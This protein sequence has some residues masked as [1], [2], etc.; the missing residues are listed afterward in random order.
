MK[1]ERAEWF[2]WLTARVL[3]QHRFAYH[4]L[5]GSAD[6]VEAALFA[7][8]GPEAGFGYALEPD[9]RGPAPE[10]LSAAFALRLLDEIGRCDHRRT[11]RLLSHF[12]DV[13]TA[14]GGLPARNPAPGHHPASSAVPPVA[15]PPGA[16]QSTGPIIGLLQHNQVRHPWLTRATDFCWAAVE[17]LENSHPYELAAAV[18][19]L[20]GI[21]DQDRA[22]PVARRLGELVRDE[23]LAVLEPEKAQ[24][25]PLMPGYPPMLYHY[26]HDYARTPDSLAR[27]WFT[28]EEMARALDFLESEQDHDGGWA[29]RFPEW[30]PSTSLE[31]RPI[32]TV[33]ALLTLRAYG[34]L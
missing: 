23:R 24:E 8:A 7:Y 26:P 14:D 13:S 9:L 17:S 2:V 15:D 28:D 33:E 11:A 20:D 30:A 4:F 1:L 29:M 25:Y 19:F 21:P 18:V 12:A 32:L 22:R 31:W 3:E 16:L 6:S 10:P 27:Q 34:R 5:G